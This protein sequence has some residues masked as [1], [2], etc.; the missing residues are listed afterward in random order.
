MLLRKT[1][2]NDEKTHISELKTDG[3]PLPPTIE[4]FQD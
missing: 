3:T 4:L 1:I 2:E